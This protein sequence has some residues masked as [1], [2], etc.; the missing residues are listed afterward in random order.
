MYDFWYRMDFYFNLTK[1]AGVQK[2]ALKTLIDFTNNVI[3]E[4][5][6]ELMNKVEENDF[7]E[8]NDFNQK[9]KM[10][11][12]DVLLQSNI[13]GKPL[14]NLDIR[15]EVDTFMFEVIFMKPIIFLQ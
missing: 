15:E 2:R 14:S 1:L 12:L 5:R 3:V 6:N 10:A 9:R 8:K 13:D 11:F 4:R 7:K